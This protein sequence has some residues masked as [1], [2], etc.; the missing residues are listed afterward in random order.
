MAT[1][2]ARSIII[3]PSKILSTV[4]KLLTIPVVIAGLM[5]GIAFLRLP[6]A[7][8]APSFCAVLTEAIGPVHLTVVKGKVFEGGAVSFNMNPVSDDRQRFTLKSDNGGHPF[9]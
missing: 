4:A 5:G 1:G 9:P 2:R 3:L 6:S 8:V 7:W